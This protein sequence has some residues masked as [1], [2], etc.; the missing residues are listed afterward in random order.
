MPKRRILDTKVTLI[1]GVL[2]LWTNVNSK[3]SKF[4]VNCL[5]TFLAP[6]LDIMMINVMVNSKT[7]NAR[8][9][10]GSIDV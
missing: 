7:D 3:L 6:A 9:V 1:F 5:S 8:K 4:Y 10:D 2:F